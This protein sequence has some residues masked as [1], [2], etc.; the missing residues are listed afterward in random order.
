MCN[1]ENENLE[2]NMKCIILLFHAITF[3]IYYL[4]AYV[5]HRIQ[6]DTLF[7]VSS[8]VSQLLNLVP[9]S[10]DDMKQVRFLFLSML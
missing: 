4:M 7:C 1:F 10:C 9:A 2:K 6:G 3:I 5:F 8:I